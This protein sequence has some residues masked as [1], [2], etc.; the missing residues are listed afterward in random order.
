MRAL[1]LFGHPLHPAL[2]HFPLALWVSSALWDG[3][4][5]ATGNALW[6]QFG[7]W[8][9]ALG[10]AAA[11]PA[12][13]AGLIDFA[14]LARGHPAATAATGHM[15]VMFTA[16]SVYLVEFALRIGAPVPADGRVAAVLIL[17]LAGLILVSAGG[18]LGG[19]LV[20]RHGVGRAGPPDG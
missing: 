11:V 15:L 2:V 5:A 8:S 10:L 20:Y 14:A 1:R 6:W 19:Q 9:I 16:T 13:I 7:Y 3:L 17:S 4:G 18:W 12:A